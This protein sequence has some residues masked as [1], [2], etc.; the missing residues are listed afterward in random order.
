M[1]SFTSKTTKVLYSI[2]SCALLM[3]VYNE[4]W[5]VT[6]LLGLHSASLLKF[7][8]GYSIM[9]LG[10]IV[11]TAIVIKSKELFSFLGLNG[12]IAKGF[13]IALICVLPLF[14]VFPILGSFNTDTNLSFILR[15][16]I[17]PGFMEE[18]MFRAFMFG[19]LFRYAKTG[20]IWAVILPALLF[21]SLHL[22]QGHDVISSLAAFGVTFLGAVY[23]SWMYA[24]WNF[25][26][27]VPVGL[28]I[29]MNGA[30]VIFTVEGTEVAAGGLISNIVRVISI[31]L[32][33]G[34]TVWYKKRG[35]T[36]IF[37]YPIW[38]F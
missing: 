20:F 35:D 29:L 7:I 32:A 36:K 12:S 6:S 27:W 28:H 9:F 18:F 37:K 22:Y 21:G 13:G 8:V 4:A 24:E 33:I 17:L 26:L 23:F 31:L 5:R 30:W 1:I 3:V 19:L 25:N 10:V 16:S 34:I 2:V 14:V 11:L 15:K 38:Q